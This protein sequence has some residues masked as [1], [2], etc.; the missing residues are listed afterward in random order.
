MKGSFSRREEWVKDWRDATQCAVVKVD[1]QQQLADVL[2]KPLAAYKFKYCVR[3]IVGEGKSD[4][5]I[6]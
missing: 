2:T 3:L 5:E 6:G 4:W 1:K